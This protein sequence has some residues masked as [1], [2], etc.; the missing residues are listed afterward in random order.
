MAQQR[1]ALPQAGD[2]FVC[3]GCGEELGLDEHV[4]QAL[5]PTGDGAFPG[6]EWFHQ[7]CWRDGV[8]PYREADRG[9]LDLIV[10]GF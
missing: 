3:R 4:V 1:A 10:R 9:R 6:W 2:T 8:E 5:P 7:A